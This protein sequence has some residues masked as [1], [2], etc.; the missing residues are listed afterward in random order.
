[1][2]KELLKYLAVLNCLISTS[3][4]FA[5]DLGS[6]SYIEY[7]QKVRDAIIRK[8]KLPF[9]YVNNPTPSIATLVVRI[10]KSGK[11]VSIEWE[12]K[13]GDENFDKSCLKTLK[14]AGPLPVP[15]P[16]L[17]WEVYQEGFLIEFDPWGVRKQKTQTEENL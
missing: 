16:K 7:Q 13:S 14:K 12:Q 6:P 4:V 3:I 8:W 5:S 11:I 10:D 15:P 17:E 1:M 2:K 9:Q